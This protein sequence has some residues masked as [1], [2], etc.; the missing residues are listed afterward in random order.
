MLLAPI[1]AGLVLLFATP[2]ASMD[3]VADAALV[4]EFPELAP[5]RLLPPII[6]ALKRELPD[7]R[8]LREF[9][10]CPPAKIKLGKAPRRPTS[11]YVPLA[12]EA[13][14]ATG[15]YTGS[16]MYGAIFREGKRVQISQVQLASNEGLDGIINRAIAKTMKDCPILAEDTLQELLQKTDRPVLKLEN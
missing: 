14:N 4:A 10:I 9:V 12:F 15:G 3:K 7:A 8:S 6:E 5:A 16:T 11:W 2:A 13:R 1:A